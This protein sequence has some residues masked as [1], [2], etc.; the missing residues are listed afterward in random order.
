MIFT[1]MSLYI[2]DMD[3]SYSFRSIIIIISLFSTR[4]NSNNFMEIISK[5]FNI[6]NIFINENNIDISMVNYFIKKIINIFI[7]KNSNIKY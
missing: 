1:L 2:N 6:R 4:N 3:I 5:N 7:Y